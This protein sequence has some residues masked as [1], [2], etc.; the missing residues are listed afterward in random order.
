M[1]TPLLSFFAFIIFWPLF[2]VTY[3]LRTLEKLAGEIFGPYF[4]FFSQKITMPNL[5]FSNS[6]EKLGL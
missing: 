4:K 6:Y 1:E 5:R 2:N 3:S